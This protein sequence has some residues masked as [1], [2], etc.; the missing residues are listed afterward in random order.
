MQ[1]QPQSSTRRFGKVIP[2]RA[3]PVVQYEFEAAAKQPS[4]PLPPPT[5]PSPYHLPLDQVLPASTMQSIQSAGRFAFHIVGDVGGVKDPQ[6]QDIVA[7]H[8]VEDLAASDESTRPVFFY[9][10][11]DVVYYYG[12][13]GDYYAQFYEP[14]IHYNAPIFSI[15]G[16]HDGDIDPSNPSVPSLAA[17]V[18]NFCAT[19]PHL[20]SEA[21][22]SGRDTMTQPNVYWTLETPFATFIGLYTNVPEGGWMDNDQIAW[23]QSELSSAP[24]NK[25]LLVSMHHPIYSL[26][27]YHSGSAY[28][29]NILDQAIQASRRTPDIVFAGHVHNYQR[30][31]RS[32]NSR[33]VPYIVAGGGGYWNLHKM[34]K[35]NGSVIETPYQVPGEDVTLESYDATN[36]GYLLME[37]DGQT[38]K[39]QYYSVSTSQAS[40]PAQLLDSFTLNL[41]THTLQ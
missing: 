14:Y 4:Q 12:Q 33:S 10:L 39:G 22:D 15:P 1:S 35:V 13:A 40:A 28:M 24:Q 31:T 29:G 17:F 8:M 27:T 34:Q 23:L 26:D 11:G 2:A 41:Q 9:C 3:E 38:L 30:F 6:D 20:S 25:A 19:E 36:H 32:L 37:V 18:E 7:A 16:N 5:G 21:G